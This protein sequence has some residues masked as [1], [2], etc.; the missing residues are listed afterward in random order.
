MKAIRIHHYGS[1]EMLVDEDVARPAPDAPGPLVHMC[2]AGVNP[3]TGK[4][5][6]PTRE[7]VATLLCPRFSTTN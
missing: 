2:A 4:C 1:R 7:L 6:K 3:R 5:A